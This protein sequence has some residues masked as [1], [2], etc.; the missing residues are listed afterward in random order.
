MRMWMVDPKLMC[1]KHLLGEHVEIHMFI[2]TIRKNISI[3]GYIKNGLVETSELVSRH[4]ALAEE[5]ISRGM[6]HNS[7]VLEADVE[8]IKEYLERRGLVGHV[9]AEAN[10]KE[11]AKRC[12]RC[13]AKIEE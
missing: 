2:G 13:R 3:S 4:D 11:L 5:I 10:L 6:R 9:D 8:H 12:E 1:D 7:P